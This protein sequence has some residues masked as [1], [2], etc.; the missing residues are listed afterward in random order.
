[1]I[2]IRP[3]QAEDIPWL[4]GQLKVFSAFFGTKRPLFPD[5]EF[6]AKGLA[7]MM[8][9]HLV[10][11]A[12][13]FH[14]ELSA[15]PVGFIAGYVTPHPFNPTIRTLTETFWWVAEEY[16]WSRAGLK[17]LNAFVDWGRD[18]ADWIMFALE[19][20]SPVKEEVLLKRGFRLQ[21]RNYLCEV[22]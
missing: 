7:M 5:D 11:V 14:D 18:N 20:K 19:E 13:M 15:G 10:L 17:L 12:E 22:S 2:R 4:V 21:E 1:M 8:T 9:N 16:R 6:A 3:A